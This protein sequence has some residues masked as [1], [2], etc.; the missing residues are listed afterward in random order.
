MKKYFSFA[1]ITALFLSFS[2]TS[3]ESKYPLLNTSW[4]C[5]V[6]NTESYRLIF[7]ETSVQFIIFYPTDRYEQIGYYT[8]DGVNIKITF[9]E[10]TW[11]GTVDGK[12]MVF[13]DDD[14]ESLIFIKE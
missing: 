11:Y 7:K 13:R 1:V 9:A 5:K 10:D 8:Y 12:T 2:F 4:K 6:D 3:C 14:N